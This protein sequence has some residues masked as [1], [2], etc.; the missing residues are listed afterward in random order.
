MRELK[1]V[2]KAGS[3]I[4]GIPGRDLSNE[5][6][7][8]YGEEELLKSGLYEKMSGASRPKSKRS[9]KSEGEE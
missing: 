7:D 8:R 2:G 1:F 5:E 3:G 9:E 6:V 4:P